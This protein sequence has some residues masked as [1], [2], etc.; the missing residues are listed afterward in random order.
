VD[1]VEDKL[2]INY[3]VKFNEPVWEFSTKDQYVSRA[4]DDKGETKYRRVYFWGCS[5]TYNKR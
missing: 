4:Y 1:H 2:Y 3:F 5:E